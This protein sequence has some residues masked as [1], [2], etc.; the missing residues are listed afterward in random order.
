MLPHSFSRFW[1]GVSLSILLAGIPILL[2]LSI[3]GRTQEK[4]SQHDLML[5][6]VLPG[7]TNSSGGVLVW[8][9][10]PGTGIPRRAIRINDPTAAGEFTALHF[11]FETEG[12]AIRVTLSIVY[13]DSQNPQQGNSD[14]KVIGS[15]LI[16]EGESLRPAELDRFGIEPLELRAISSRPVLFKPGEGPRI[17]NNTTA[18]EVA[19]LEKHLRTYQVWLKNGSGKNVVAYTISSGR[20]SVGTEGAWFGD[21][22]AAISAGATTE[23][24]LRL[25]AREVEKNGIT[26]Q[27][28]VFEDESFEGDPKLGAQFSAKVEGIKI[29][30]P[31]VLRRIEE[32]LL[33]DDAGLRA[34][35]DKL[36]SELWEIPEA[37]DKPSALEF[38]KTKFSFL[39]EKA[40]SALYED[41][42][43]GLYDA[44][45]IALASLGDNRRNLRER[46]QYDDSASTAKTLREIL[47]NLKQTFEK[48]NSIRR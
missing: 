46:A 35:F 28:A 42:K 47:E 9:G 25:D 41:L 8:S 5:E 19:R 38:L 32:T 39:G 48:I 20:T 36:E 11:R 6:V 15:Y 4:I 17:V 13:D 16:R 31:H 2:A 27:V 33:I 23:D 45:N 12:N 44:R 30:A 29:Q 21:K 24:G 37:M 7:D 10:S 18:L 1:R 14:R 26:I 3:S 22:R 34:A 43:G 40:V